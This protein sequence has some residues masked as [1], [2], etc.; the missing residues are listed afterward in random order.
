VSS[1]HESKKV[2]PMS[3][4]TVLHPLQAHSQIVLN[5][6]FESNDGERRSAIGGGDSLDDAIAFARD[7]VPGDRHWR[8][9]RFGQL[10]GA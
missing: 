3:S 2:K 7:S 8:V 5:V 4:V 1:V 10:F 9:I 6:V